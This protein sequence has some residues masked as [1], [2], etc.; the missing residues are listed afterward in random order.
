MNRWELAAVVLTIAII[1]GLG[2]CAFAG[3]TSALAAVEVVSALLTSLLLVLSE[4][5]QR[6]PF[7]DLALTSVFTST[8][9]ALAFARMMEREL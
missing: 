1:P 4:G 7:V 9:G 5:F 8:I 2:V 6:Q 3:M